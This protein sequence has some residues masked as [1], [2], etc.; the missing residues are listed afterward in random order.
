MQRAR[1]IAGNDRPL[2]RRRIARRQR[3][4]AAMI[5]ALI[6]LPVLGTLLIA[7]PL[8]H[9]RYAARQQALLLA[10]SAAWGHA[11]SGCVGE[12]SEP[13]VVLER[14]GAPSGAR[15]TDVIEIA[16]RAAGG[17]GG[18]DVFAELPLIA[19]ALGALLGELA[20]VR[21]EV[22]LR[23]RAGTHAHVSADFV[24]LCNERPRDV[25]ELAR[26]VFC[27]RL[28]IAGCGGRS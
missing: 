17:R 22:A 20:R 10:R 2:R 13:T 7:A 5:E 14:A 4:A 8:L 28:P 19:D 11:L 6:V 23:P 21:A 16:R 25:F 24:L 9:E 27:E 3:A 26:Q 15:E 18:L 1:V 12:T